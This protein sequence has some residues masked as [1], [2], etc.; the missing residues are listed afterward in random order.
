MSTTM[1]NWL[2]TVTAGDWTVRNPSCPASP[3]TM[4]FCGNYITD[5]TNWY[6]PDNWSGDLLCQ[7]SAPKLRPDSN[8]NVII[9][10]NVAKNEVSPT[11]PAPR[12]TVKT[13]QVLEDS[14]VSIPI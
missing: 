3:S 7:S 8:D 9:L 5:P 11:T 13:L 2:D 14:I 12:A 1:V 10:A 6:Q 4:Y